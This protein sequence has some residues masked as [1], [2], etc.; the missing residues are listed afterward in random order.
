MKSLFSLLLILAVSFA[1]PGCVQDDF[2]PSSYSQSMRGQGMQVYQVQIIGLRPVRIRGEGSGVGMVGG[3]LAGGIAGSMIGQG[4]A[5]GLAAVGGALAGGLLGNQ[6]EKSMGN[7]RGVEI[8]VRTRSGQEWAVV[9]NDHGENF[10]IGEWVRMMI[11][12][13]R[14][15]I[16]R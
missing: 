8:T 11:N 13:D 1:T 7:A 3:A 2:G 10:F 16:S 6:A 9:Q 15:I 4:K 12:G 5:S 14:R